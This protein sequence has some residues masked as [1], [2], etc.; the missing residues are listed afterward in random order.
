MLYIQY[1]IISDIDH[2]VD[3]VNVC[4]T[5]EVLAKPQAD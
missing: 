2:C 4:A 5:K 3:L 1:V